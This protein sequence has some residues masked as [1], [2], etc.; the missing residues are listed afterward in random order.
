MSET[1]GRDLPD[2]PEEMKADVREIPKIGEINPKDISVG[3]GE[4]M[5][6]QEFRGR[7]KGIKAVSVSSQHLSVK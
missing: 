1:L 4:P 2:E 6:E 3:F 7:H 5:T